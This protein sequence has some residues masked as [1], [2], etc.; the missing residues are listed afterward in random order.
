MNEHL[1][2]EAKAISRGYWPDARLRLIRLVQVCAVVVVLISPLIFIGPLYQQAMGLAETTYQVACFY[3]YVAA[4][5][6]VVSFGSVVGLGL[7]RMWIVAAIA[8]TFPALVA[9]AYTRE[10][11]DL[12]NGAAPLLALAVAG[13][14]L[15]LPRVKPR[16]KA[17]ELSFP[18][19]KGVFT[20]VQGGKTALLNHHV[21]SRGQRYARG[22]TL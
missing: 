5:S 13:L 3:A 19:S 12:S 21:R 11:Y 17:I 9:V 2:G 7:R 18:L 10:R 20:V 22:A 6:A 4:V 14:F 1:H 15:W 16:D 8:A